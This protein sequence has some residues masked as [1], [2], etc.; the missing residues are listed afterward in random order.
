MIACRGSIE[1]N[2]APATDFAIRFKGS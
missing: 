1:R 2:Q